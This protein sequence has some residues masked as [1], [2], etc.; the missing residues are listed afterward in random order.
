MYMT[1]NKKCPVES[2]IK[3]NMQ[4]WALDQVQIPVRPV[5]NLCITLDIIEKKM[6]IRLFCFTVTYISDYIKV[7]NNIPFKVDISRW[8]N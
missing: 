1:G 6:C 2:L 3:I 5:D 7:K 8:I 4:I